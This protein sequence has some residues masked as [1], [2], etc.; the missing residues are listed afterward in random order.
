MVWEEGME[1][2]GEREGGGTEALHDGGGMGYLLNVRKKVSRKSREI[3]VK[4]KSEVLM[5]LG[6]ENRSS[7]P[8]QIE[9]HSSH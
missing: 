4:T 2:E 6:P 8:S 7:A 5:K 3:S 1:K 9:D